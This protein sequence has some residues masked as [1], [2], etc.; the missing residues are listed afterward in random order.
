MARGVAFV[1]RGQETR[2][3]SLFG[4]W[5]P[6]DGR[7]ERASTA[8]RGKRQDEDAAAARSEVVTLVKAHDELASAV[9]VKVAD[10]GDAIARELPPGRLDP[11]ELAAV[12]TR[13]D[14]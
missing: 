9:A 13:D 2:V 10:A 11:L 6:D 1:S 3:N 5:L 8:R 12:N 7:G 4:S 14:P